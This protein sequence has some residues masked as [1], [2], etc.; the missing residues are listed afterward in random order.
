MYDDGGGYRACCRNGTRRG[1][2]S[3]VSLSRPVGSVTVCAVLRAL[4]PSRSY[5]RGTVRRTRSE[6]GLHGEACEHARIFIC[7]TFWRIKR[8]TVPENDAIDA[9]HALLLVL[10]MPT[11]SSS[12]ESTLVTR[13][14]WGL[15]LPPLTQAQA[16]A[17]S[18]ARGVV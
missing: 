2:A 17:V 3:R 5:V 9:A 10:S 4:L 1:E 15:S 13:A 11:H 14:S 7:H 18:G 6:F 8:G 12:L 16:S